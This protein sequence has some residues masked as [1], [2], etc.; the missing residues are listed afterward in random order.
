MPC[1]QCAE[2]DSAKSSMADR[3]FAGATQSILLNF[4][5]SCE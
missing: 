4:E 2:W 3:E 5:N 1:R